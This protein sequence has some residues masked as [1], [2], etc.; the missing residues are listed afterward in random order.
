MLSFHSLIINHHFIAI[1]LVITWSFNCH[2]FD[3]MR[4]YTT[5]CLLLAII[6]CAVPIVS[7]TSTSTSTSEPCFYLEIRNIKQ[8]VNQQHQAGSIVTRGLDDVMSGQ[9]DQYA[10]QGLAAL[11]GCLV[12]VVC[13]AKSSIIQSSS[14]CASCVQI[15]MKS[16]FCYNYW[17]YDTRKK[18]NIG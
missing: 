12:A 6:T 1:F 4:L 7:I 17:I 9:I 18:K 5:A 2:E 13:I 16:N 10:I 15:V 3:L 14:F 8:E 11:I